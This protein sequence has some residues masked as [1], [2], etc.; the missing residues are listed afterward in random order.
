MRNPIRFIDLKQRFLDEKIEILSAV[1]KVCTAGH[2]VLTEEVEIL[3]KHLASYIGVKHVVGV[4]SGTDALMIALWAYGIGKGDEVITSPISFVATVG[5]I[6]HV[7][8]RPVFVDV[9]S[10]QNID[11]NLIEEA[12]TEKTKA[13]LPVHWGGRVANMPRIME[14]ARKRNLVVIED[15]AQ[16]MGAYYD[17]IHG[18]AFGH[19]SCFSAHP[20]KN[21]SALG[22]SGFLC[23]DNDEIA[24]KTRLYRS[25]GLESRDNCLFF[26]VNSRLDS[27]N[28]E[29]LKY[30]LTR[31]NDI[32]K[33]RRRNVELYREHLDS[34]YVFLPPED[35]NEYHAYVMFIVQAD[36][37]DSL[38]TYL[39]QQG[40]E[41]YIYYGTPLHLQPASQQLGYRNGQFPVAELQCSKVLAL[42][43]HQYLS[44]KEIIRVCQAVNS[45]YST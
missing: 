11:V 32:V 43:H 37:R 4:N 42:P 27:L 34:P 8:A 39:E 10:N 19:T 45:F 6:C 44:E 36:D 22:D 29:V 17:G 16:A 3:E 15:A 25:H 38:Q 12:I 20:L 26:G 18:G 5:S 14:I 31:L 2:F 30:R 1:E 9:A 13:I 28:A 33:K 21:L 35:P 24:N 23:T 41:S 7:G 40:I